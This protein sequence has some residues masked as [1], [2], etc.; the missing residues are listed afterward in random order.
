MAGAMAAG[1][2]TR[3]RILD[4][5]T[6]LIWRDGYH[7]VSVDAICAAAGIRKGSFYHA[8]ASKAD[9]LLAALVRVRDADLA[10]IGDIYAS[11]EPIAVKFHRHLQWF[12]LAQ[13]RLKTKYGF[14]PGTFN[15]VLDVN[16][17]EPVLDKIRAAHV[18]HQRQIEQTI[19]QILADQQTPEYCARLA[20]M[21]TCLINGVLIDGRMTN[22]LVGYEFFPESVFALLGIGPAPVAAGP[23]ACSSGRIEHRSAESMLQDQGLAR[24]CS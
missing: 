18:A 24:P 23:K 15:M 16:V 7:A 9:L 1:I 2:P 4:A 20:S 8:F 11:D 5:A 6:A 21:I 14:V 10:E 3:E 19:A 22:S 17:P 13:S 12:G